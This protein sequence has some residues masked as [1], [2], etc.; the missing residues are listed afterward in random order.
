MNYFRLTMYFFLIIYSLITYC[1]AGIL[2]HEDFNDG[3]ADGWITS[4][5]QLWSVNDN[6]YQVNIK[7]YNKY[8]Y[9]TTGRT[10]WSNYSFQYDVKGIVG[11]EKRALFRLQEDNSSGYIICIRSDWRGDDVHLAKRINGKYQYLVPY[12]T[13]HSQNNIWYTVKVVVENENIKVYIKDRDDTDF[14]LI[15]DKDDTESPFLSG[16]IGLAS[17]TGAAGGE[18]TNFDNIIVDSLS[19]DCN[20]SDSDNDGVIDQWDK[21]PGTPTNSYVNMFGCHAND[22]SAVSGQIKLKGNPLTKGNAM[23]IQSG[24]IFQKSPLDTNGF[25]KFENVAEEKPFSVLI[26]NN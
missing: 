14:E 3:N 21:C 25:Y 17:W 4:N 23:L 18:T 9:S 10:S 1:S 2:F 26:R 16:K 13:Y 24:E 15:I 19:S 11:V 6:E 5:S 8:T 7:G 12:F 20:I 22:N